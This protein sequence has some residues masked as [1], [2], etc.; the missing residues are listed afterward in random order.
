[1]YC[2]AVR[3]SVLVLFIL[4]V[5]TKAGA[6]ASMTPEERLHVQEIA[7]DKVSIDLSISFNLNSFDI[8]PVSFVVLRSL[9]E[10]LTTPDLRCTRVEIHGYSDVAEHIG[11]SMELS[12][13]RA[14]TV[15]R[16]L[17][18]KGI[19][20]ERMRPRGLGAQTENP[21]AVVRIVNAGTIK[22][23]SESPQGNE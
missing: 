14:G 23:C 8:R 21:N 11:F 17:M 12:L 6:L 7:E 9:A 22:G 3:N 5:L 18:S 20:K 13:L 4:I 2:S 1:M 16:Y 10:A 15:M 19:S